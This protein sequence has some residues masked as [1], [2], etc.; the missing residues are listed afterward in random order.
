VYHR[1]INSVSSFPLN[2][3]ASLRSSCS[4]SQLLL[5]IAACCLIDVGGISV[6]RSSLLSV[7]RTPAS[8]RR[9]ADSACY[10][11]GHLGTRLDCEKLSPM[12]WRGSTFR[13]TMT[14]P[15]G[16]RACTGSAKGC[17]LGCGSCDVEASA[18]SVRPRLKLGQMHRAP[19]SMYR[20]LFVTVRHHLAW[21][22]ERS[23]FVCVREQKPR[24][25]RSHEQNF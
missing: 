1:V 12:N 16:S 3:S 19:A 9:L 4:V 7:A 18:G 13:S 14:M 11:F 8:S 21:C 17:G 2:S 20:S 25:S 23:L 24:S 10:Q 6:R 22:T 5:C 15:D